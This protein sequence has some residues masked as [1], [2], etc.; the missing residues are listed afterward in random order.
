[1]KPG[2]P[3]G[4]VLVL[5]A[6][7]DD[8]VDFPCPDPCPSEGDLGRLDAHEGRCLVRARHRLAEDAELALDHILGY[9]GLVRQICGAEEIL[10]YVGSVA[11]DSDMHVSKISL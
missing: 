11:Q 10:W 3:A 4:V 8:E 1:M 6:A 7:P 5:G 2:Q 9:A